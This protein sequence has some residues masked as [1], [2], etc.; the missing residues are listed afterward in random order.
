[1]TL[2]L[3]HEY[4]EGE[5]LCLSCDFLQKT[6]SW[7][8]CRQTCIKRKKSKDHKQAA[9]PCSYP[10]SHVSLGFLS[11]SHFEKLREIRWRKLIMVQKLKYRSINNIWWGN[12]RFKISIFLFETQVEKFW[13]TPLKL[14]LGIMRIV[15]IL[16]AS[17]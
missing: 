11:H 4:E 8:K 14:G 10:C 12:L 15:Y 7:N 3:M 6:N 13:I 2:P 16:I 5:L 9:A 17:I 1:M